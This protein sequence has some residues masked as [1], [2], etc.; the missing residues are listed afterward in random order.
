VLQRLRVGGAAVLTV[1]T[2]WRGSQV[3]PATPLGGNAQ[4][5]S[6]AVS[7]GSFVYTTRDGSTGITA[8]M[9]RS[10]GGTTTKLADVNAEAN[11]DGNV[12]SPSV[13]PDGSQVAFSN[14]R[15]PCARQHLTIVSS[16]PGQSTVIVVVNTD[17]SGFMP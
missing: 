2:L 7:S 14:G 10:P 5:A 16:A 3:L 8:V 4:S 13:S 17:G 15:M 1:L 9:L 12:A 11:T 6:A